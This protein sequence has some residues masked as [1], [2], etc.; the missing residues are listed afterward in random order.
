MLQL[1]DD[2]E[3]AIQDAL[4]QE[5]SG[6][7]G[8]LSNEI[9]ALA[10]DLT[11]TDQKRLSQMLQPGRR[12]TLLHEWQIPQ[13]GA[14]ALDDDWE[15]FENMLRLI[16]DFLHDGVTLRPALPDLLDML[17]EEAVEEK[18]HISEDSLRLWMFDSENFMGNKDDYYTP[19]NSDLS[20]CSETGLGNPISLALLYM[21]IG[22]RLNME[23]TG[24]NY[25]GHFLARIQLDGKP[26]LVDCFHKGRLISV[27]EIIQDNKSISDYAKQAILTTAPLGHILMRILRN[28]EHSFNKL[29]REDDAKI[30]R[31]I[32]ER[33][34]RSI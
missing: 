19:H 3:P 6:T 18:A 31:M 10:I 27:D 21:L 22:R 8:D 14:A 16:A 1:L 12:E 11:T 34:H 13:G 23:I 4:R 7:C 30:F 25:P 20:W 17:A 15:T 33:M 2:E 24:C 26:V 29:K 28:L 5:F 9:A 32:F